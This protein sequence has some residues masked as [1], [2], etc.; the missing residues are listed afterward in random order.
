MKTRTNASDARENEN[1][2]P[3]T[4]MRGIIWGIGEL[5]QE[6]TNFVGSHIFFC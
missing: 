4:E 2:K 3:E 1:V 5:W 6:K